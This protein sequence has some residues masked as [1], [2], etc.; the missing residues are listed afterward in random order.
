MN[1]PKQMT[2]WRRADGELI[3]GDYSFVTDADSLTYEV[4]ASSAPMEYVEEV[5]ELRSSRPLIGFP[6]FYSCEVG[7][8]DMDA[9]GWRVPTPRLPWRQACKKHGG[10]DYDTLYYPGAS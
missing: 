6:Y 9:V 2:T 3:G 8:C 7:E 5:W 4:D 1:E 10:V